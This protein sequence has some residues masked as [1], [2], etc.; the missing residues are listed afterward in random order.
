MA[1][2]IDLD[3][4]QTD[5]AV[6]QDLA[7]L[8]DA[9]AFAAKK[10]RDQRRKDQVA[11]PYINHPIALLRVLTVEGGV[12]NVQVLCA[13]VLHDTLEDTQT[14]YKELQVR[15]GPE[16]AGIVDEV[17]D[18]K[19][20]P[21]PAR[22]ALQVE[23]APRL[24]AQAKLVKLADKICNLRDLLSSPPD[25]PQEQKLEY[26][27]WAASVIDGCRGTHAQL[28]RLFDSVVVRKG[29]LGKSHFNEL[30][31]RAAVQVQEQGQEDDAQHHVDPMGKPLGWDVGDEVLFKFE[32]ALRKGEAKKAKSKCYFASGI[33]LK[34]T[35]KRAHIQITAGLA[36]HE[37][38][39]S[40]YL[41]S[42]RN[43]HPGDI[44]RRVGP[45]ISKQEA[46]DRLKK[47]TTIAN[48]ARVYSAH[49]IE[50]V[51]Q[52]Q[53][54]LAPPTGQDGNAAVAPCEVG[55][56]VRFTFDTPTRAG[57]LEPTYAR[58]EVLEVNAGRVKVRITGGNDHPFWQHTY[59][60][61]TRNVPRGRIIATQLVEVAA[62]GDSGQP[63]GQA[64]QRNQPTTEAR[65]V[66]AMVERGGSAEQEPRRLASSAS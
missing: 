49:R 42:I 25:W 12:S 8:T 48:N 27:D 26:F 40:S 30:V 18:E 55:Q 6:S 57:K 66:I 65:G 11:S 14:S 64:L 56:E 43:V 23:H 47:G 38:W 16:I 51:S 44:I 61:T 41:G 10:H 31:T 5:P 59:V 33:L 63:E 19:H 17:T 9:L 34:V 62:S 35:P 22:K 37:H 28:E 50:W 3:E 60:G 7:R 13:A 46:R 24:S 54:A 53:A 20:L 32:N 36:V 1:Q 21:K 2:T 58:G 15:Y 29:E 52:H 45:G 4:G 39:A